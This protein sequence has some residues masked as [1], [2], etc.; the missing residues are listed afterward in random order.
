MVGYIFWTLIIKK[1]INLYLVRILILSKLSVISKSLIYILLGHKCFG[2]ILQL[3]KHVDIIQISFWI[4]NSEIFLHFSFN[5]LLCEVT[6][7][8]K[9]DTTHVLSKYRRNFLFQGTPSNVMHHCI[10]L[11]LR[12]LEQ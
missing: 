1:Q 8:F 10:L 3:L 6:I 4:H 11:E 12:Q 5:S 7:F 9:I 2:F